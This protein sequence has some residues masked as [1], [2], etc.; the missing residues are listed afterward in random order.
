[1]LEFIKKANGVLF[2]EERLCTWFSQLLLAVDYLHTNH[3]LHRDLKCSNIFLNKDLDIKLG[4]F[5]LAKMLKADDLTSS[6]V[7]TPTYMCPELLADIPY[8]FKSDIWSLGCCMFEMAAHKPAFKAFDMQG[9]VSKVNK[10]MIGPLPSMYSGTLKNLIKSML[11]KNPEHRPTAA[12]L[13][14]NP[15]LK[16]FIAKCRLKSSLVLARKPDQTLHNLQL[17]DEVIDI[18]H[19]TSL[20]SSD[21]ESYSGSVKAS[22]KKAHDYGDA[23]VTILRRENIE[24]KHGNG[25]ELCDWHLSDVETPNTAKYLSDKAVSNDKKAAVWMN[26]IDNYYTTGGR[27]KLRE[28]PE[29]V[30]EAGTGKVSM[31]P[32][33]SSKGQKGLNV[34]NARTPETI[35]AYRFKGDSPKMLAQDHATN[36]QLT[37]ESPRT[38]SQLKALHDDPTDPTIA[39]KHKTNMPSTPTSR[40]AALPPPSKPINA[41]RRSTSPISARHMLAAGSPKSTTPRKAILPLQKSNYDT[42]Q[43]QV[44]PEKVSARKKFDAVPSTQIN[45]VGKHQPVVEQDRPLES[46]RLSKIPESVKKAVQHARMIENK[47]PDVSVNSPRLDFIPKFSICTQ[48]TI[49]E[50]ETPHNDQRHEADLP[51]KYTSF[52]ETMDS[53]V[54][55]KTSVH[56]AETISEGTQTSSNLTDQFNRKNK[57]EK[58]TEEKPTIASTK[59]PP[60][61]VRPAYNDVI[62]VIRHSTFQLAGE[63]RE[64]K[65][66]MNANKMQHPSKLEDTESA[67]SNPQALSEPN[68]GGRKQHAD[69]GQKDFDVTSFRQRADALEGLLELSAQLLQQQRL[70]ELTIVLK[71]FGRGTSSPM[72]TAMWLSKSLKSMFEGSSAFM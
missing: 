6:V 42:Y 72:E 55:S 41:A 48:D 19:D 51:T 39:T 40:R 28:V 58:R 66:E 57:E 15:Y 17:E 7:G 64:Q 9:L 3:I 24:D 67:D 2:S 63:K 68:P 26:E 47:S 69:Y 53:A 8:G 46:P 62:H 25:S 70:E 34:V 45:M 4:D 32:S 35:G 12:E 30:K 5:G 52:R 59:K 61:A 56:N 65:D 14:Q 13:L 44:E 33:L 60:E 23:K 54:D 22:L 10:S 37:G 27:Q 21:R 1:M 11:R 31:K 38:R 20:F 29:T 18:S 49:N 16:P 50:E 43:N 36:Y 71:P